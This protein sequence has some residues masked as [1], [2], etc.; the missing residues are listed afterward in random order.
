MRR[1]DF[2]ATLAGTALLPI[3][4]RA[5]PPERV[6]RIGVLTWWGEYDPEAQSQAIALSQGLGRFGWNSGRNLRIE[7]RRASGEI[8][9]M[10]AFARDLV[11]RQP[12]VLV[13]VTTPAVTSKPFI[14]LKRRNL[15]T[16][17]S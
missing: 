16:L 3:A 11:G 10:P 13:A 15:T 12:D 4:V 5:E 6:R 17:Q 9:R 7:Y 2:I 1:R 8:N 14:N